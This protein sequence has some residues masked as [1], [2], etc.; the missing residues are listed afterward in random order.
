[1]NDQSGNPPPPIPLAAWRAAHLVERLARLMRTAD[2]EAGMNPAQ[3]EALRYL[4]RANRFSRTPSAL[5]EFL[6][7]SRGTVSQTLIALETKGLVEK[8]RSEKDARSLSLVLTAAGREMLDRDAGRAFAGAIADTG[9]AAS[10]SAAI[11]AT[12]RHALLRRGGKLFG[13]CKTCRHFR[14]GAEAH[15]CALLDEPLTAQDAEAICAEM[16]A[17]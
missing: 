11:E 8:S 5:A 7:S 10:M 14:R 3:W 1:M 4:A 17:A 13:A 2:F 6:N 16:D 12:L 15:H 9:A